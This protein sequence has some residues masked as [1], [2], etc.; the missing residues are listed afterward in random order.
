MLKA[1][2][3][4]ASLSRGSLVECVGEVQ[5]AEQAPGV[6]AA[7]SRLASA[8]RAMEAHSCGDGD[9]EAAEHDVAGADGEAAGGLARGGCAAG[10]RGCL[11]GQTAG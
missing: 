11:I 3:H 5:L 7:P 10:A 6:C 2:H 8:Q 9:Q 4:A 1:I